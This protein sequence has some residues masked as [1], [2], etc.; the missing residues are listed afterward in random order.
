MKP[1][2]LVF[3][4]RYAS[5][6]YPGVGTYAVGLAEALIAARPQWPW[7]ILMP[8]ER[9]FDLSFVPT[10]LRAP[11]ASPPAPLRGHFRLGG[12][13]RR[14]GAAI[15]HSPYLLRPW[16]APCPSILTVHDVIPLESGGGMGGAR[17]AGYRWL[18]SDA[19]GA[20]CVVTD[21]ETSR[22]AIRAAFRAARRPAPSHA[23]LLGPTGRAGTPRRPPA[24]PLVVYP[25]CRTRREA[26]PWPPWPRSVVLTVGINKPHKNLET[27]IRALALIPRQRRP[28]LVCAGPVDRRFPDATALAAWHGVSEDVQSLG[29]VPEGQLTALYRSATLFAFPTRL[30]GFGLPLLEAMSLGVPAVTSDLPVLREISG[31]ATARV[32]PDDSESWARAIVTLLGDPPR[33]AAM[34]REGI[35][36]ARRFDY[37]RAAGQLIAEYE[38]LVPNLARPA[39]DSAADRATS[40]GADRPA[41]SRR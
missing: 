2:A 33:L 4:L 23:P 40:P 1:G 24:D 30:E 28:L 26:E 15:Y 38:A 37:A 12:L 21:S 20:A 6:H 8:A 10:A 29:L 11:P 19:L 16:G 14:L 17:R 13:L 31:D 41:E 9:R 32:A 39:G 7:R 3:D 22:T 35:E 18:V 36:R 27:L 34:A 5:A 25:G